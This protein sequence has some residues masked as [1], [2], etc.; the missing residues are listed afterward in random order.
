[1]V[2]GVVDQ[3]VQ[4]AEPVDGV[5][6]DAQTGLADA[7]VTGDEDCGSAGGLDQ[8][9][10]AVGIGLFVGQVVDGDVGT[11]SGVGDRY[12]TSDPGV[13]AGDQCP[14]ARRRPCPT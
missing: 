13:A 14:H 12:L 11:F 1:M 7:E 4:S 5:V 6:D 2:A 3:D 10:G 9:T 8:L